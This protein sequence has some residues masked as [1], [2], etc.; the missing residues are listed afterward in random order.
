[1]GMALLVT[2]ATAT[3][4]CQGG[5]AT[6]MKSSLSGVSSALSLSA[7]AAPTTASKVTD[8]QG[9]VWT[10]VKGASGMGW[11]VAK[12]GVVDVNTSQVVALAVIGGRLYQENAPGNWYE[13]NL[14]SGWTQAAGD[15]RVDA[16]GNVW[17]TVTGAPGL[18]QQIAKNGVVDGGTS[19]VALLVIVGGRLYQKNTPGN[20]YEAGLTSGWTQ[21]AGDPRSSAAAPAPAPPVATPPPTSIGDNTG[22]QAKRTY[23]FTDAVGANTHLGWRDTAGWA[24]PAVS[25]AAV[26][27]LGIHRLRDGPASGAV[28]DIQ[29]ALAKNQG[30][31]FN[32]CAGTG[33]GNTVD[34]A[35]DL[36]GM[37]RLAAAGVPWAA[38][39]YEGTNEFDWNHVFYNGQDSWQNGGWGRMVDQAMFSALHGD[40][41][42]SRVLFV[43]ATTANPGPND[44]ADLG[45]VSA[46]V[47]AVSWHTYFGNGQ[48]PRGNVASGYAQAEQQAPGKPMSFTEIGC[49][50]YD[51]S[52]GWGQCASDSGNHILRMLADAIDVGASRMFLYELIENNANPPGN[53]IESRFG[54][55]TSNGTAKPAAVAVHNLMAILND[56]SSSSQ[57]FSAGKLNYS[58]S[59]LPGS[60]HSLLFQKSNGAFELI[61]WDEEGGGRTVTANFGRAHGQLNVYQPASNGS[62]VS[63]SSNSGSISFNL[64]DSLAVIEVLN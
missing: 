47:D 9:N 1:M 52:A 51:G 2:A 62:P 20:W 53:D 43:G 29:V 28:L 44:L 48:A 17:T 60:G 64:N 14:D 46:F 4:G 10:T 21:V 32:M 39:T 41:A 27:Y 38:D 6:G 16:Q 59:G 11:Q 36:A 37:K 35:G 24:N 45:N 42:L 5:F 55:F 26:A 7:V 31:K 33:P 3:S 18:G 61:V 15:P 30:V 49:S 23:A 19:Q 54:L 8:A 63:G 12:N 50:T 25:A 13:A 22:T 56:S 57:S 40:S 34:I 58:L